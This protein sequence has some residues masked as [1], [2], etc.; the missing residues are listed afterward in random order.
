[1]AI[2]TKFIRKTILFFLNKGVLK[3]LEAYKVKIHWNID[4]NTT[5]VGCGIMCSHKCIIIGWGGFTNIKYK[6]KEWS[7][8]NMVF[9]FPLR[10]F[11]LWIFQQV[12]KIATSTYNTQNKTQTTTNPKQTCTE[13][14][15]AWR[16]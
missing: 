9:L 10:L 4:F 3:S 11:Y 7:T 15:Q 8:V 1:M 13:V 12:L 16:K 14:V 2:I 5:E 6:G